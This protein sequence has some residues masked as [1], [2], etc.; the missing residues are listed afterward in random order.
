VVLDRL[1]GVGPISDL[2]V[3]PSFDP[4]SQSKIDANDKKEFERQSVT[5]PFT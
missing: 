2:L 1:S 5:I 3:I 4:A